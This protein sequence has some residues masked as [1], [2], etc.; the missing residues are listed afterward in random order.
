LVFRAGKLVE[1]L[2]SNFGSG[3]IWLNWLPGFGHVFD[4]P[5][6]SISVSAIFSG[7]GA[8]ILGKFTTNLGAFSLPFN[9]IG[10]IIGAV[11]ANWGL[12]GA[13]PPLAGDLQAPIIF[14]LA[15]MSMSGV[16]MMAIFRRE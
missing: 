11:L 8:V 14:A 5:P 3:G 9:Y 13:H 15:G 4:L 6:A 7:V 1:D 10:L 16:L 2:L 12:A